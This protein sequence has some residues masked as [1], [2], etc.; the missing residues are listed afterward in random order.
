MNCLELGGTVNL[1]CL[2]SSV[3]TASVR[4]FRS[5]ST[6]ANGSK[7]MPLSEFEYR[8]DEAAVSEQLV[9]VSMDHNLHVQLPAH[10][11][12]TDAPVHRV[13]ALQL[14]RVNADDVAKFVCEASNPFGT[15]KA[16]IQI[17]EAKHTGSYFSLLIGIC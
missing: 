5:A 4:W 14:L 10:F 9:D 1:E 17:I 13:H 8:A 2:V 3:P 16:Q 12:S 15:G 6:D 7:L 11:Q